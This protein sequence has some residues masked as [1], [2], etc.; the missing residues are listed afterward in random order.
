MNT[1]VDGLS[2]VAIVEFIK[3]LANRV[4]VSITGEAVIILGALVGAGLAFVQNS[5]VFQGA[6]VGSAAV[7]S[8]TLVKAAK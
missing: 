6:L 5:D 1:V 8:H 2:V 4:G 3:R 7:G